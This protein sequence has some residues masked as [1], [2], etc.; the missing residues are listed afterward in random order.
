MRSF[1]R[2]LAIATAAGCALACGSSGTGPT[3][4]EVPGPETSQLIGTLRGQ[5]A[6]VEVAEV[7][8]HSSMPF[9]SVPAVRLLVG[10][11]SVHVFEYASV[12]EADAQA[13]R[14]SGDG[15]SIGATLVDWV[16]IPHFFRGDRLIVLYVGTDAALILTLER[17][18]GAQFAGG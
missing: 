16:S 3:T 5:G 2:L 12:S 7:M 11:A 18:L 9:F 10:G 15:S 1:A 8:P 13:A 17:L 14:V 6:T 4:P